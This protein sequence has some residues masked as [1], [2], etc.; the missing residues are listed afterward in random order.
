MNYL[1]TAA[2]AGSRF[3]KAGIKPPKPLIK[4]KGIELI[5]W[6]LFSFQF[7]TSDQL[8]FVT[9]R[10]DK[11]KNRILPKLKNIYPFLTIHWLEIDEILNGQLITAKDAINYFDIK[12]N[13]VIHNCDT[14]YNIE[15]FDFSDISES[16]FGSVPF[17]YADGDNWSFI[18]ISKDGKYIENI[19]EK[20]RIS[21]K[22]SVGTYYFADAKM[23]IKESI[24]YLIN[25]N[26]NFIKEHYIAPF[27]KYLID[28]GY[29]ILPLETVHT[30]CY[31]TLEELLSSFNIS[32]IN[33]LSENDF[34][35]HQR[36]T[37][38]VDI[39]GTLC[40]PP[41]NNSYSKCEKYDETTQKLREENDCGTY[42]IL[43]TSRNMRTFSGNI[44]L[45][46]KYTSVTLNQWLK[47]NNIPFD[48]L[49]FGKPWG[50]GYLNYIDDKLIKISEFI[51]S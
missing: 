22:C 34:A 20:I 43:Y 31:G 41:V 25:L 23:F 39:D 9:L 6:S 28:K 51:Q 21:S 47:D 18:K 44:G 7:K 45:I 14:S 49:Y 16:Y 32:K 36:K 30:K 1:I 24:E 11:V 27:Y 46:N 15:N 8:Y 48:E 4:V 3:I 42:I 38:V 19:Q 33:L 37:L 17:F 5:I 2:G 40:G 12:G 10:R 50:E 29:K 26:D 13:I 35:G